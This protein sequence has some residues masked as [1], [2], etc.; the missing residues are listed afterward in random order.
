MLK[1]SNS[2]EH[3]ARNLVPG[4]LVSHLAHKEHLLVS[5]LKQ[6]MNCLSHATSQTP[7]GAPV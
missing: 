4:A 3:L 1:A 7:A 2:I 6:E 5:K